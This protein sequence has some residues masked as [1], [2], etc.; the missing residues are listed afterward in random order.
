ME[1][2]AVP[3]PIVLTDEA[4]QFLDRLRGRQG[5]RVRNL[6]VTSV[7]TFEKILKP[8]G[9]EDKRQP[10]F[11]LPPHIVLFKQE[12]GNEIRILRVVVPADREN[13]LECDV[14]VVSRESK[15]HEKTVFWPSYKSLPR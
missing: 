6:L 7:E 1:N 4:K 13:S 14:L 2:K 10:G 8:E 11:G 5:R 15:L 3:G 12:K 9:E